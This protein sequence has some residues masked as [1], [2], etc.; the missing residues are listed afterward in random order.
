MTVDATAVYRSHEVL[1]TGANGFVGKVT[2]GLLLDRFRDFKHLH[3]LMRAKRGYSP[4]ERFEKDVLTSPSLKPI[5]ERV[6]PSIVRDKITLH[7]GDLSDRLCGFSDETVAALRGRIPLIINVAGLVEFTPPVDESFKSNV[8]GAENVVALA[9][10][11]G[12]KL[13]HVSTCFVCGKSDGLVEEDEPIVGF[14]PNRKS[15]ADDS[16]RARDEAAFIRARVKEVYEA[17]RIATAKGRDVEKETRQKLSD[18]GVQRA[19]QWGWVNTYTYSKSIGEQL[20]ASEPGLEYT[21]VRPAIVEAALEFPFPGWV[22]GGRTAAPLIM[23]AMSGLRH[24]PVR[25]DAPMEVVPVDQVATAILTAGALL[26]E[27]RART[28]YHLGTADLNPVP[29]KKIVSW[30]FDDYCKLKKRPRL[31][32]PGVRLL[33]PEQARRRGQK[34]LDRLHGLQAVASG[35]RSFATKTGLPGR[36]SFGKAASALR[37]L[38]LQVTIREQA[39]ELYRPFIYDNRFIFESKNIRE[40]NA[41]LRSEDRTKLPWTPEKINWQHYWSEHEV[42]GIQKWVEAETTKGWSFKI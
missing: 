28:V 30:M 24:W 38:G 23:M 18:L 35:L 27:G 37:M 40:A 33:T 31:L 29:L 22:E 19:A 7:T 2:L 16:F 5:V 13:V 11:L 14:Y 3:I 34:L 17:A 20:I 9:K 36:G 1:I 8:D 39:L 26:I 12:A 32:M 15:L 41:M 25:P 42:K 4:R 10:A 21:M 6:D